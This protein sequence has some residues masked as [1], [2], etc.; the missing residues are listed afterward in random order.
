MKRSKRWIAMA[1]LTVFLVSLPGCGMFE[2]KLARAIQKMSRIDNLHYFLDAQLDLRLS[3][4]ESDSELAPQDGAEQPASEQ[5]AAEEGSSPDET[6]SEL[7]QL[8]LRGSF[9]AEG[10]LYVNPLRMSMRSTLRLPGSDSKTEAYLEKEES[11]YY[12]YSRLNDGT[13]WQKQGF[14]A[15]DS[16]Q[17]KGLRY[18][19][20]GAESFALA[21]E[22]EIGGRFAERYDGYLDG[23]YLSGLL[24]LYDVY[25][26]L[27]D[28]FGLQLKDEVFDNLPDLPVSLW[29]DR[30]TGMIIHA[31]ADLT[32]VAQQ[33]ATTQLLETASAVK[34]DTLGL[35]LRLTGLKLAL[36]LSDFNAADAFSI[37]AEAKEAWGS[38]LKPW[39]S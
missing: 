1:L 8:D 25:E 20:K 34:L 29:I 9:E 32:A 16:A 14:A 24:K 4:T 17:V 5:E 30:E 39:E 38:E 3:L 36:S 2:T 6:E 21:G 26:L 28:D 35:S 10:D 7:L 27:A 18:I 33:I 23:E 37:P 15:P 22:E 13:L 19:V 12:Y 11:A 31:E